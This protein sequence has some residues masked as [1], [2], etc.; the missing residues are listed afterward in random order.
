MNKRMLK[1]YVRLDGQGRVIAG[2]NIWRQKKP[3]VGNWMEILGYQCC[4]FTTSTTTTIPPYACV[5]YGV[6]VAR[7]DSGTYTYTPCGDLT[8][9]GPVAVNGPISLAF[10]A[11]TDSISS[12]G[13]VVVSI[14]GECEIT[15]TTTSTT[16]TSTTSTS[17]SSTTSTTTSHA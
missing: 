6:T 16:S 7:G 3:A 13:D 11:V 5:T 4:N 17:T 12:T 14:L 1:M 2:S 9:L 10:C 8:P 15:T